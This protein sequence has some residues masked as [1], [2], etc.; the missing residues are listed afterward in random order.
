MLNWRLRRTVSEALRDATT[1]LFNRCAHC[2][3]APCLEAHPLGQHVTQSMSDAVSRGSDLGHER[4]RRELAPRS[5]KRSRSK[6][7]SR[8]L[9]DDEE[10]LNAKSLTLASRATVKAL[11]RNRWRSS[12]RS[13]QVS[14]AVEKL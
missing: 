3:G 7:K 11:N 10:L 4:A 1:P 9:L 2:F 6:K 13:S 14:E 12:S 8:C 5:S